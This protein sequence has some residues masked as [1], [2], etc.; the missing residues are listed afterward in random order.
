M[1]KI[2]F[3]KIYHLILIIFMTYYFMKQE[4]YGVCFNGFLLIYT[5]Q[6]LLMEMQEK[7]ENK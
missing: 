1:Q 7:G 2:I 4:A 5:Q 6:C 3:W